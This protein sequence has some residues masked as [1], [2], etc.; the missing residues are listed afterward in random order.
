MGEAV[1]PELMARTT[2]AGAL[3]SRAAEIA[4]RGTV[5]TP[6]PTLQ[7]GGEQPADAPG[8]LAARQ[9]LDSRPGSD[10]GPVSGNRVAPV[11]PQVATASKTSSP[12]C[13][14]SSPGRR[15][16]EDYGDDS[17]E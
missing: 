17:F 10:D 3:P 7:Q 6:S 13:P 12:R 16:E 15:E 1:C 11:G 5:A 14:L 2:E 8:S 9:R 4:G